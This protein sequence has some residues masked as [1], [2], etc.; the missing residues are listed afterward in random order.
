MSGKLL[1]QK[2]FLRKTRDFNHSMLLPVSDVEEVQK[3]RLAHENERLVIRKVGDLY[4]TL[5]DA[6]DDINAVFSKM[7]TKVVWLIDV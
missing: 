7:V 6:V 5:L 4:D 3:V 1:R 2:K